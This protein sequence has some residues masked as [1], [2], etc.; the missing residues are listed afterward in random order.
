MSYKI[1]NNK[2]KTAIMLTFF[3]LIPQYTKDLQS[4]GIDTSFPVCNSS[5]P[6]NSSKYQSILSL[7]NSRNI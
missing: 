5:S 3:L 1:K 4:V 2:I 7:T 6:T